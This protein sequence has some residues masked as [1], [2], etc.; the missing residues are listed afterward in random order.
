MVC[1]RCGIRAWLTKPRG[2]VIHLQTDLVYI[3]RF[4]GESIVIELP[5]GEHI[6]VTVVR[7]EGD[8]VPPSTDAPKH[9]PMVWEEL[10]EWLKYV[11]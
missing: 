10:P 11:A 8:E 1:Q 9:M 3:T 7:I 2:P 4:P 5:T 6:A